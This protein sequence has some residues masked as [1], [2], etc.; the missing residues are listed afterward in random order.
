MNENT[1]GFAKM[2]G[3]RNAGRIIAL[4]SIFLAV[5]ILYFA[6]SVLKLWGTRPQGDLPRQLSVAG[7]GKTRVKPDI[8]LFTAGVVTQAAKVKDAQA[9]NTRKSNAIIEFLKKSGVEEKDIKT[10][11]YNVYPQYSYPPPMPPC[12]PPGPCAIS[13]IRPP[14]ISFYQVNQTIEVKVRDLGKVDDLLAGVVAVGSNEVE[15]ITFKVDDPEA[16]RAVAR[17]NAIDNAKAKA[18]ALAD[19]LGVRLKRIVSYSDE[20]GGYPPPYYDTRGLAEAKDMTAA[21]P[22]PQVQPGEQEITANVTIVYEFR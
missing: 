2:I 14:K 18:K 8:A 20:S 12:P 5:L 22:G 6:V 7:E 3:E 15:S 16:A 11:H 1:N 21:A 10:T 17:K 19:D 4:G 13:E 9:E